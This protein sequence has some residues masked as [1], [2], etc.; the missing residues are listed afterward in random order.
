MTSVTIVSPMTSMTP[1]TSV[2]PMTPGVFEKTVLLIIV[3]FFIVRSGEAKVILLLWQNIHP[4]RQ[5]QFI[6]IFKEEI[7]TH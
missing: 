7:S 5:E 4:H 6:L 1:M 3:E 2:T